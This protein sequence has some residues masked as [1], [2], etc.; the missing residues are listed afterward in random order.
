MER[1]KVYAD[2]VKRALD[3][4][5]SAVERGINVNYDVIRLFDDERQQYMVMKLGWQG[6]QRF[7]HIPLHVALKDDKIWIEAD[8]TEQGIATYFLNNGV[9]HERIVLGFQPPT[10]RPHTEFAVA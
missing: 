7:Q 5:A 10:M 6:K 3:E 2:L 8:W 1:M 9:P 4:Y